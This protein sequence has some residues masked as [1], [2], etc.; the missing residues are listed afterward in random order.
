MMHGANMKITGFFLWKATF[1][2]FKFDCYNLQYVPK[3][4]P[5][6]RAWF[7]VIE[8]VTLYCTWSDNR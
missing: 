4:K 2:L 8:A 6:D 3:Y 1:A 5:F 7:E